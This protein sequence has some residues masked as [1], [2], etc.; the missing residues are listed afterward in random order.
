[1]WFDRMFEEYRS[2]I[3]KEANRIYKGWVN[4][5]YRKN[6]RLYKEVS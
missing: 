4:D 1:V 3:E 6:Y 5:K 2:R